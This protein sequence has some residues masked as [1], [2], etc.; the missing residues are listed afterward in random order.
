MSSNPMFESAEGG[1]DPIAARR[2]GKVLEH[3]LFEVKRVV[4]GQD[5]MIERLFVSLLSRGH[6]LLEGPPGL[7]KT[8]A[9]ETV[10]TVVGGQFA[11]IQFTPDLVPADLVGTRIYRPAL[12]N[13]VVRLDLTTLEAR[14]IA[15][16]T[17]A[18][19]LQAPA[20][21]ARLLRIHP[22]T[23]QRQVVA[24]GLPTRTVGIG[25]PLMNYSSDVLVRADGTIVV[26]GPASGSLIEL[27]RQG[28]V[29]S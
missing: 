23:G 22:A 26:T 14:I 15:D 24:S 27:S 11:R 3:A 25:L 2:A 4:V 9:A 29:L 8:L 7:A 19:P 18:E 12:L 16:E 10:A 6:V 28:Q 1:A 5:R 17:D 20:D 13:R 21:I